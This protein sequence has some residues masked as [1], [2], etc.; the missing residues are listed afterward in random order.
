[1]IDDVVAEARAHQPADA[2]VRADGPVDA[3]C[4][5]LGVDPGAGVLPDE[6]PQ[7]RRGGG[8]AHDGVVRQG[9]EPPAGVDHRGVRPG[10]HDALGEAEFGEELRRVGA[11]R[12][13]RLGAHVGRSRVER[14]GVQFA[15]D[16]VGGLEDVDVRV[17]VQ[18][19]D[20]PG[21]GEAGEA[22]SDDGVRGAHGLDSAP[23][24]R[25]LVG[26]R[27]FPTQA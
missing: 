23:V 27:V 11:E 8:D 14:D 17:R 10:V 2:G 3:G 7:R 20:L 12:E 9:V 24:G 13:V 25:V 19:V 15:A 6:I 1:M 5:A 21:G 4:V 16:A 22:G 26:V 18:G